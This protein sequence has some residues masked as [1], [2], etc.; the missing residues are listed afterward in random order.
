MCLLQ[1]PAAG[2]RQGMDLSKRE[3]KLT[4]TSLHFHPVTLSDV[5]VTINS[6]V[7]DGSK[8]HCSASFLKKAPTMCS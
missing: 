5:A 1:A 2:H 6:S 7:E 8:F 3:N 4:Y